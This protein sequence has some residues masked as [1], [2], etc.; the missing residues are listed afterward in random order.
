M[1]NRK[2]LCEGNCIA[3]RHLDISS[4]TFYLKPILVTINLMKILEINPESDAFAPFPIT[5]DILQKIGERK[6]VFS[7]T[8]TYWQIFDELFEEDGVLLSR[9][10]HWLQN[11]LYFRYN[12]TLNI[13]FIKEQI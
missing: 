6:F 8:K 2:E 9:G 7:D 3:E 5:S 1:I 13:D 11:Y 4:N 10:L 12:R